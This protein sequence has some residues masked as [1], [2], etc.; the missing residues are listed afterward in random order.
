MPA[1]FPSSGDDEAH[2]RNAAAEAAA[3][4]DGRG[5]GNVYVA[6]NDRASSSS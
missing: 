6:I 5:S 4:D 2:G 1:K 3:V